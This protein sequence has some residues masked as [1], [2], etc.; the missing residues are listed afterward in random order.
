MASDARSQPTR[1]LTSAQP[2]E[3]IFHDGADEA[4]DRAILGGA[5]IDHSLSNAV[6]AK[7]ETPQEAEIDAANGLRGHGG[8]RP[9]PEDFEGILTPEGN[10]G[11]IV[12]TDVVEG[13]PFILGEDGATKGTLQD[14]L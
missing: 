3:A 7:T 4:S 1:T 8:R 14:G 2:D 6:A 9:V 12:G 10:S 5:K 13:T 11:D